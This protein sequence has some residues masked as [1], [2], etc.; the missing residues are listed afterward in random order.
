M[1]LPDGA[2]IPYPDRASAGIAI[3]AGG[4]PPHSSR[5]LVY[6]HGPDSWWLSVWTHRPPRMER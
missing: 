5:V 6:R 2:V 3:N 4:M 1:T